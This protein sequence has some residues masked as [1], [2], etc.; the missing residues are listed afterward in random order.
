MTTALRSTLASFLI[1]IGVAGADDAVHGPMLRAE[2]VVSIYETPDLDVEGQT[3]AKSLVIDESATVDA[4][5]SASFASTLAVWAHSRN[6]FLFAF[7]ETTPVPSFMTYSV[8]G[9]SSPPGYDYAHVVGDGTFLGDVSTNQFASD[10]VLNTFGSHGSEF[11]SSSIRNDLSRY[12]NSF[13]S[14]SAYNTFASS[15]PIIYINSTPVCYLT[16]NTI[17]SPRCDPDELLIYLAGDAPGGFPTVR[18]TVEVDESAPAGT[19][20]FP[21]IFGFYSEGDG[22]TL[23]GVDTVWFT[24]TVSGG[25]ANRAPVLASIGDKAITEGDLLE[26]TVVASDQDGDALT[27]SASMSPAVTGPT[28]AADT[29]VFRWRPTFAQSG[30]YSAT[31]GVEDG[32]GGI[33]AETVRITV[34][35][36]NRAPELSQVDDATVEV[37]MKLEIALSGSDPDGDEINYSLSNQLEGAVLSGMIFTWTPTAEQVGTVSVTFGVHDEQGGSDTQ[38]IEILVTNPDGS[39]DSALDQLVL[40]SADLTGTFGPYL[41][42]NGRERLFITFQNGVSA[43]IPEQ[44]AQSRAN[45]ICRLH[46]RAEAVSWLPMPSLSRTEPTLTMVT[47]TGNQIRNSRAQVEVNSRGRQIG[48]TK[49]FSITCGTEPVAA[50]KITALHMAEVTAMAPAYPN[51]FNSE[52]AVR[53]TL[54]EASSVDLSIYNITGQ[55]IRRL[56][57]GYRAR[58]SYRSVWDG[59]DDKGRPTATGTYLVRLLTDSQHEVRKITLVR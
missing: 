49:F 8:T 30:V 2:G 46:G 23:L 48:P 12:G 1:A 52:T 36:T 28:F 32:Q 9:V 51:P 41:A 47:D 19:Y 11:S 10:S 42:M 38:T 21:V 24:I 57:V 40:R 15:P 55:R 37:G 43:H 16:K 34:A 27:Y 39:L 7:S 14:V 44:A 6:T 22:R 17:K 58:G 3:L 56:E 31:F 25:T 26:F 59:A 29:G 45:N 50:G 53:F 20:A 13:S 18:H 54:A 35:N 4:G 33:D 5:A